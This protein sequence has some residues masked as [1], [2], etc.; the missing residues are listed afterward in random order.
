VLG[1]KPTGGGQPLD[2]QV[3]VQD[4]QGTFRN[5]V[6]VD[7]SATN[8]TQNWSGTVPAT[9]SS[10]F[11]RACNVGSF[12]G[13]GNLI[14]ISVTASKPGFISGTGSGMGQVGNLTG[15]P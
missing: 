14:S 3:R 4:S 6:T 10:G 15:C 8:G 2:I 11:Y 5:D 9:G 7:A 1:Y 13:G 12:F